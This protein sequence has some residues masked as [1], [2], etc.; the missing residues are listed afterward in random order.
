M[1]DY[2]PLRLI[3]IYVNAYILDHLD[4]WAANFTFF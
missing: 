4:K 1:F 3:N 2:K